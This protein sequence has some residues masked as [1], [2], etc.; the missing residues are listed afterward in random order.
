MSR[1]DRMTVLVGIFGDWAEAGLLSR[2]AELELGR[3]VQL[4]IKTQEQLDNL[5]VLAGHSPPSE[6]QAAAIGLSSSALQVYY[7]RPPRPPA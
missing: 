6:S 3:I 5:G 2:E 7:P 1:R 4:G